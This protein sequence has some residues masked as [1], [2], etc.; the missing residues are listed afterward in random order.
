VPPTMNLAL[1]AASLDCGGIERVVQLLARGLHERG[2][3]V[4]V[5]TTTD[6]PD[7]FTLPAGVR[8]VRIDLVR[9]GGGGPAGPLAAGLKAGRGI[10]RLPALRAAISASR[11]DGVIS[12]ADQVNVVTLVATAGLAV[13][14]VVTEHSIAE[15][16]RLGRG[17]RALRRLVYRRAALL[18]CPS[19]GI[20]GRFRWLPAPRRVV[21]PNPVLPPPAMSPP[22]LGLEPGTYVAAM[23]R[24]TRS[25]GFDLLIR[26]F[27]SLPPEAGRLVILG[28]GPERRALEHLAEELGVRRRLVL[29]GRVA[30]PVPALRHALL[31][32]HP[33]RWESFGNAI[34]EAMACGVPVVAAHCPH[35]PGEIVT[36][37]SDGLLVPPEDVDAL[38]AA[39]RRLTEDVATR[40]RMAAAAVR[41]ARRFQLEAV[42]DRWEA[43]ALSRLGRRAGR[44]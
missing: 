39:I 27:A 42:L 26:A 2:H 31:F 5:I 25:K 35:G 13:P 37:G 16:E 43:E 19:R 15:L 33:A 3:R 6:R 4:T 8:R 18:V 38:A 34:V 44:A 7:F 12:F 20:A 10:L 17:W 23:G 1:V 40:R 28:E 29:A 9:T 32:V 21:I 36:H 22:P 14:V 24:L 41:K 30:D 11:A